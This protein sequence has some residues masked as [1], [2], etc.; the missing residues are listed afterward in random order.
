MSFLDIRFN[1]FE[2]F[3]L[4]IHIIS[5]SCTPLDKYR[6]LE[7]HDRGLAQRY[8]GLFNWNPKRS[9]WWLRLARPIEVLG[10]IKRYHLVGRWFFLAFF[11]HLLMLIHFSIKSAIHT[12]YTGTNQDRMQYFNTIY[13]PQI[14]GALPD[15]HLFNNLFLAMSLCSLS[16]R[17]LSAYKLVRGSI[18]NENSYKEV[19][20]TQVNFAALA[21]CELSIRE[22]IELFRKSFKHDREVETNPA[23][24]AAHLKVDPMLQ[25]RLNKLC[26]KDALLHINVID[27][28]ECF[29]QIDYRSTRTD[30]QSWHYA[31]PVHKIG[32]AMTRNAI[33]LSLVGYT[34]F[35]VASGTSIF[36]WIYMEL[37]R[38]YPVGGSV[39]GAEVIIALIKHFSHPL[40][41]IGI[42][43]IS[44]LVV[45]VLPQQV[46]CT[47]V[48]VDQVILISRVHK[49]TRI[50]EMDLALVQ[51]ILLKSSS[52]TSNELP[53]EQ[54]PLSASLSLQGRKF[55]KNYHLSYKLRNLNVQV[56]D[57][58]RL[59][60]VLHSEFLDVKKSHSTRLNMIIIGNGFSL[61]YSLSL[62]FVVDG[63]SQRVIVALGSL[64]SLIMVVNLL[65]FCASTERVFR[66]MYRLMGRFLV[67]QSGTLS[68]QTVNKVRKASGA[69]EQKK[70]RSFLI[71]GLYAITPDSAAPVSADQTYSSCC[72][73]PNPLERLMRFLLVCCLYGD[74]Y[75]LSE[76]VRSTNLKVKVIRSNQWL[77]PW[78]QF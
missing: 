47:F 31:S 21:V 53:A 50:L 6:I 52:Y 45:S 65:I 49:L 60:S 66:N 55:S 67:N 32:L 64:S 14:G 62:F 56:Q 18:V 33:I 8:R 22:W 76:Q 70:D 59:A 71:A 57:H 61:T 68:I 75:N 38:S 16:L 4:V 40:Y 37:K 7:E 69:F 12:F 5:F 35:I 46:D 25:E 10:L 19:S 63:L 42:V 29:E 34:C 20:I 44:L 2:P 13:Y 48:V 11:G 3:L 73:E 9:R 30:R 74:R 41:L 39:S 28:N 58:I 26:R 43:E 72:S 54:K 1:P 27:Y 36:G 15:S 51:N 77:K 23:I 78:R 17:L 24:K